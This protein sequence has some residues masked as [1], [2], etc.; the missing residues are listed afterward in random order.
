MIKQSPITLKKVGIIYLSLAF[1]LT[2][3][4][5]QN[6]NRRFWVERNEFH[7]GIIS[8]DFKS[9]YQYR[10]VAPFLAEA[11]GFVVEKSLGL[12]SD[13]SK[14]LAREFFYILQRLI[15]T[16][17][18]FIFFHLYLRTWFSPE[19]ALSGTLILACLHLY[20]FQHYYYQPSSPLSLMFLTIGAYLMNRGQYKGW[21]Y[22]LTVIGS[23]ARET[24]GLIAPLHLSRFGFNNQT[25]KHT[26]G[27]FG[28]WLIIQLLLRAV[29]GIKPAF[30][31]RPMM[32]NFYKLDWTI[33]FF[34]IL[35]LIPL[36]YFKHLPIYMR[37]ALFLFC[38]PLILANFIYGKV[39]EIRLFL[40]L[41]IV[42]IP[43]VLFFLVD[44]KLDDEK[45]A[46]PASP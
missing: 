38:V 35:W 32:V 42:I 30:E 28:V 39:E 36:L 23:L 29:F 4:H 20:A 18:L 7:Q 45:S 12:T 37:R 34:S 3:Y 24:F 21:L 44:A 43:C 11:G 26:L 8:G 27:L 14:A 15:A 16:F 2:F 17:I 40:D 5:A 10:V 22:P 9:P 31:F 6:I 19:L 1:S 46:E 13:K 41:A 25:L 33:F